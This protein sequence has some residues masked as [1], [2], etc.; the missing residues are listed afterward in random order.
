[1]VQRIVS[2][3]EN[4][5]YKTVKDVIKDFDEGLN[6]IEVI[7][8]LRL[9]G[10]KVKSNKFTEKKFDDMKLRWPALGQ[11]KD[12]QKLRDAVDVRR[13][14]DKRERAKK[15]PHVPHEEPIQKPKFTQ[16]ERDCYKQTRGSSLI[17]NDNADWTIEQR[18]AVKS[19]RA[20]R[21]KFMS[22][23]VI[24]VPAEET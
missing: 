11:F 20:L 8:F 13:K 15:I 23:Q 4:V 14:K 10:H 5:Y 21:K 3:N 24:K 22:T 2:R 17:S 19:N 7:P 12:L 6:S 9:Y 16:A 18:D 1:M